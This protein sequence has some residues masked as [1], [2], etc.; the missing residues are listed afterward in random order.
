MS[1]TLAVCMYSWRV[2]HVELLIWSEYLGSQMNYTNFL[3]TLLMHEPQVLEDAARSIEWKNIPQN[4]TIIKH[5]TCISYISNKNKYPS[6]WWAAR[7][8]MIQ[9]AH[10]KRTHWLAT[11]QCQSTVMIL[12]YNQFSRHNDQV[13]LKIFHNTTE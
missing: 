8:A 13:N 4:R 7:G 6:H 11:S 5:I 3:A 1:R 12:I 9:L 2:S 10:V